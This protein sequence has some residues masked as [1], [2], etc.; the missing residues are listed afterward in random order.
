MRY[1]ETNEKRV[2]IIRLED[3]EIIQER[4]EQFAIAKGIHFAKLQVLGGVDKG[5]ILIVGP[6]E[7]RASTIEPLKYILDEM[8]EAVGNGTIIPDEKG[9]PRIHCH[10]ACGREGKTICGEIRD[11]VK[12]WH[13]MEVIITEL[14][15]CH[16][17]R[18]HDVASGFELLYPDCEFK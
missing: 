2:F 18:K 10:L 1:C 17:T 4:I 3:G 11:G 5:S 7:G 16:V 6:K 14:A 15:E 12:V 13:I 9:I 8:H